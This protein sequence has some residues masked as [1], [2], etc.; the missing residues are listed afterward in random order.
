MTAA[1]TARMWIGKY[2]DRVHRVKAYLLPTATQ[3]QTNC[4]EQKTPTR[5]VGGTICDA[6]GTICDAPQ[7]VNRV[8]ERSRTDGGWHQWR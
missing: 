8:A 7:N 5:M 4:D 2:P 1:T 3:A 6:G